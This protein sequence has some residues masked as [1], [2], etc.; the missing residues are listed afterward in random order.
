MSV[1]GLPNLPW[2]ARV[3]LRQL[4]FGVDLVPALGGP[5]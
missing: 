4:D 3:K 1:I 5:R 2:Q